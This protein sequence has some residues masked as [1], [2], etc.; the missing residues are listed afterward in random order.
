MGQ[1]KKKCLLLF[2]GGLDSILVFQ[3]LKEQGIEVCGVVFKSCF[4]GPE[5]AK[6]S[7]KQI[8]LNLKVVD[9]SDEHLEIIKNPKYGRGSGM[10]P[11]IDC[12]LLMLKKARQIMQKHN[13]D[14]IATGEV[15]GE[16][17]MSQN[18]KALELLEKK[19]GLEGLLLR[20]LSAKLLEQ[21]I[22]EKEEWVSREK[23]LGIF[24][25]QRKEQ[26]KL[27]KKFKINNYPTPAGGCILCETE[28]SRKLKNLLDIYPQAQKN[29]IHLLKIGRHFWSDSAKIVIGRD[30]EENLKLQ[31]LFKKRDLLVEPK[32]TPG[33][34]A[35]IRFYNG[36]EKE[37]ALIMAKNLLV[38][39]GKKIE[40][41]AEFDIKGL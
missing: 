20:P 36:E 22:P 15:L 16:R 32:N 13:L 11:C 26:I 3:L 19:S 14:F 4:F 17:P 23:M 2:S 9:I 21:T 28:F 5:Q 30:R 6:K 8:G 41:G 29:D 40:K 34:T 35:L 27:A 24:G 18:K 7:A 10:N 38:K 31:K 25:R 39:Y 33:P 12:H 37:K 1:K